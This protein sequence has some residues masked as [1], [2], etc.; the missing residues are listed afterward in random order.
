M[1]IISKIQEKVIRDDKIL[2]SNIDIDGEIFE[3]VVK[4]KGKEWHKYAVSD[5]VDAFLWG[6]LPYA[7]RHGHDIKCEGLVSGKFL[8]NLNTQYISSLAKYDDNLYESKIEATITDEPIFTEGAC[9]TGVSCGVDCLY[10]IIENY[11]SI[12]S[13]DVS[14][15]HLLNFNEGAFGGSYYSANRS[16]AVKKIH[17]REQALADELNLPVINM[18]TN[19]EGL[20]KIPVDQFIVFAMGIM[21]MSIS[22]LIGTYLYS[23]SGGD[24][25]DFSIENSSKKDISYADLL[26]LHCISHGSTFF[27]S[28]GGAKTRFEK[29]KAIANN[30]L[31]RKHLF[32]CLNQDFNCGVCI[33]CRRNLLTIDALDL[34]DEYR[35][36]YDID[37]YK[38]NRNEALNYLVNEINFHGYSYAYLK[39]IYEIIKK[40]EPHLIQ[41]IENKISVSNLLMER[42]ELRKRARDRQKVLRAY[43]TLSDENNINMLKTYFSTKG[44]KHVILYYYSYATDLLINYADK[45]GIVIDYIVE[46]VSEKRKIPRL[47]YNTVD[48]PKCDA[49]IN[50]NIGYIKLSHKKL[51]ERTNQLII[52]VDSILDLRET[53]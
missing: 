52:D 39:D 4:I 32:S 21:V 15:T 2:L 25:S 16:F 49:I 24:Y 27:Y 42:D 14:L 3:L 7:M 1:I 10:T 6:V 28:A 36:V 44:I 34:L 41:N 12:Y 11:N 19:L 17:E 26:S 37:D 33:K 29:F 46:D 47:P 30:N 43:K 53:L 13:K 51:E 9:A 23:S 31:T 18:S 20:L 38:E 22:K 45:L 8:Y 35:E 5:R 50:C 40:R 48:Y